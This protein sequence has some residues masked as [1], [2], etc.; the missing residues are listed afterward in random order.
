MFAEH[1][2]HP[3]HITPFAEFVAALGKMGDFLIPHLFVKKDAGVVEIFVLG[4]GI[5]DAGAEIEHMLAL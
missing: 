4:L 3:N 1:L 2:L 5:G